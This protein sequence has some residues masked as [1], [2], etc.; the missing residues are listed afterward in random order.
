MR[1]T[2]ILF[3]LKQLL[4]VKDQHDK[5]LQQLT[6]KERLWIATDMDRCMDLESMLIFYLRHGEIKKNVYLK[7]PK[8]RGRLTI[9]LTC[10]PSF[11]CHHSMQCL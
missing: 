11:Y 3:N 4:F 5:I 9:T 10:G 1:S 6:E 7:T 2:V 8:V